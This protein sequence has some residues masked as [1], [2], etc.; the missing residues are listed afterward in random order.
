MIVQ[1]STGGRGRDPSSRGS[2]LLLKPD[3]ASLATGS[4]NFPTIVYENHTALVEDLAT[5]MRDNAIKPEIEVF[6]L[7]HLHSAR[8]LADRGLLDERPHMQFVV[9]IQ[10]AMPAH[11]VAIVRVSGSL[12]GLHPIR[13]FWSRTR[14]TE[15]T[16]GAVVV[17]AASTPN[18]SYWHKADILSCTTYVRFRARADRSF[19]LHMCAFDPKRTSLP[20]VRQQTNKQCSVAHI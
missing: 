10:N 17:L 1:F 14:M 20:P 2:S 16:D 12:P 11:V 4:V 18:V 15:F 5:K 7:S 19:A 3:M 8:R 6:D 9:G 13:L